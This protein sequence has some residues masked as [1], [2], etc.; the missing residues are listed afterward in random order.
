TLAEVKAALDIGYTAKD[1]LLNGL[2]DAATSYLDGWTGILGRCLVEQTWRQDFNDFRSC[3][4]LPLFPVISVAS[5]KYT[6]TDGVEQTIADP[7]YSLRNDDLGAYVEFV[8]TYSFPSLNAEGSSVRAEYV[9]G[10][11]NGGTSPNFTSTVPAAIKQAIMLM[12]RQWFDNPS[13]T[14]VGNIVSPM[15]FA[16]DALLAPYRRIRF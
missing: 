12:I 7:D 8:S 11:A 2:I 3:L 1:D 5:V 4:R 10:Y 13:A 6:D 14:N 9:A 15:P 16:V